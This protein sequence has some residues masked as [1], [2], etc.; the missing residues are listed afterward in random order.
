MLINVL[1]SYIARFITM[2]C[3]TNLKS[4][5]GKIVNFCKLIPKGENDTG[6]LLFGSVLG[7]V[8]LRPR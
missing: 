4:L 2:N 7:S 3:S 8:V 6:K 1:V 5:S